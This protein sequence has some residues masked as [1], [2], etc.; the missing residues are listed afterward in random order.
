MTFEIL[1]IVSPRH[2][3]AVQLLQL[4][5]VLGWDTFERECAGGCSIADVKRFK[6]SNNY[7]D[8]FVL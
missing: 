1:L 8:T 4:S 7:E 2:T 5:P 3:L 6:E